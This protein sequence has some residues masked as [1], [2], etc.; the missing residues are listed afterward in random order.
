MRGFIIGVPK[1]P[2]FELN[3]FKCYNF[4][5]YFFKTLLKF[6][7][8]RIFTVLVLLFSLNNLL[9]QLNDLQVISTS[10]S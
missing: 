8:M 1:R 4:E 9:A 6:V 2:Y 5:P 7:S 10:G 3:V